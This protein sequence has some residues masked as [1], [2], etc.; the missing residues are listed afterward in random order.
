MSA[1]PLTLF[2]SLLLAGTFVFLF[3]REQRRRFGS[4]E[5]DS[6]LPLADEVPVEGGGR[7]PQVPP[8]RD[9][10]GPDGCG[11]RDGARPP[12]AGCRKHL[13]AATPGL[14]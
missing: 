8:G 12:C 4:P 13:G 5:R 6:L 1:I 10:T 2:C 3:A 11:C 9:E 14:T 7:V